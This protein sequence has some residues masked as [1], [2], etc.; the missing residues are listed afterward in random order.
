[1]IF[2]KFCPNMYGMENRNVIYFKNNLGDVLK[3]NALYT[4]HYFKYGR[5]FTF[6]LESHDFW[7]VIYI[8]SGKAIVTVGN[9]EYELK[10]GEVIFV[11]PRVP[12]TVCTKNSFA[13]SA[14]A[15]FSA[16][17]RMLSFLKNNK[18][19]LKD[20]QKE[21]L[22]KVVSEAK[23][24]FP[25]RL[26]DPYATKMEFKA[27]VPFG[28][29]QWI[30][31][32][33]ELLLISVIRDNYPFAKPIERSEERFLQSVEN[34]N[35]DAKGLTGKIIKLLEE[36]VYESISLDGLSKELYFSKTYLKNVFKKSTGTSII[37]Y[38]NNLKIEEAKK[39]ISM[40]KYTFT[41]ISSMLGFSSVY[42]FTRLF[43]NV[44]DMTPSEYSLSLKVDN[45]LR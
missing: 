37:K 42:Y 20:G 30:K 39:L 43:K 21:I 22:A 3:I 8:D 23:K 2:F 15:S 14:I 17:G 38:F 29:E 5:N 19:I 27:N 16:K 40:S 28:S 12:H 18:F 32:L 35:F 10:Q 11:S 36:N 4:V 34:R 9:A 1:M 31:N 45:V 13:N 41:E 25:D 33:L 24:A 44:T 7:E 26:D 6:P